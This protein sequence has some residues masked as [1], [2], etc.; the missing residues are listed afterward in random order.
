M[1]LLWI[2]ESLF[3]VGDEV[4]VAEVLIPVRVCLR[5]TIPPLAKDFP[6]NFEQC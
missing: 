3:E 5:V 2:A 4:V 1:G 6:G